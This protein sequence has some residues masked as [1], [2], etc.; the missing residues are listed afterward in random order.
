MTIRKHSVLQSETGIEITFDHKNHK[1]RFSNLEKSIQ[2]F[3]RTTAFLKTIS[4]ELKIRLP[5]YA[6]VNISTST[7]IPTD[8][9]SDKNLRVISNIEVVIDDNNNQQDDFFGVDIS[10]IINN[11]IDDLQQASILINRTHEISP[12]APEKVDITEFKTKNKN[13]I[14]CDDNEIINLTNCLRSNPLK[15]EQHVK[16]TGGNHEHI[17]FPAN[18]MSLISYEKEK[19]Q[20]I[21]IDCYINHVDNDKKHCQIYTL[22][23]STNQRKSFIFMAHTLKDRKYLLDA[24]EFYKIM[25]CRVRTTIEYK[26]GKK[27]NG[28]FELIEIISTSSPLFNEVI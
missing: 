8:S 16:I 14:F 6:V 27:Y 7:L 13:S 26:A 4:G 10:K 1:V 2:P 15:N 17:D 25:K 3:K 5:K 11:F 19:E 12:F 18:N 9:N 23:D 24:H 21:I 28:I 20:E 22:D